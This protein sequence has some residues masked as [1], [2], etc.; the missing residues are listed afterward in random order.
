MEKMYA[1]VIYIYIVGMTGALFLQTSIAI[2]SLTSMDIRKAIFFS[3]ALT[4]Q[5][6]QGPVSREEEE[7]TVKFW[8]GC[9]QTETKIG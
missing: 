5:V 2:L 1:K 3:A 6:V 4:S 8:W 9:G 7:E